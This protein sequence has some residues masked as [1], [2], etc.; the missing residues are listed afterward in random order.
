MNSQLPR[1]L[2]ILKR[3]RNN[4]GDVSITTTQTHVNITLKWPS[5]VAVWIMHHGG[6]KIGDCTVSLTHAEFDK[7]YE[8]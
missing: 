8:V 2:R 5:D 1:R 7:A 3:I 4:Y 6:V